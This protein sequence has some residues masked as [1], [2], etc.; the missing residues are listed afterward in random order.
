MIQEAQFTTDEDIGRERRSLAGWVSLDC[1]TC[2]SLLAVAN[3]A[4]RCRTC[5]VEYR[6]SN[7]IWAMLPA[8]R[9][10][11]FA[12][13]L[14][15]YRAVRAAEG[16]RGETPSYYRSLPC[17]SADDPQHAIWRIRERSF[18]ALL[19]H[20]V[21]PAARQGSL[22]VLDLGA[23]N[24][25]LSYQL[26]R[27]GHRCAAVDINDDQHDGLGAHRTYDAP[28]VPIQA[29]FMQLPLAE[30]Q[31][32][33]VLFNA[34]LHYAADGAAA[35]SEALRVL[36]PGG[37]I[38]IIDTPT[39]HDAA[40]GAQMLAER[41]QQ[42]KQ[43]GIHLTSDEEGFLTYARIAQLGRQL[44]LRWRIIHPW[45]GLAWWSRPLR[46]RVRGHRESA[47][48]PL[49]IGVAHDAG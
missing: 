45:R 21:A 28:F 39:Y 31:F 48:F 1:P 27:R 15:S 19:R 4:A 47:D 18:A 42:Y 12:S 46:A 37:S 17:S 10:A 34:A 49:L 24:G 3:D 41:R 25:W 29:D 35:L 36:R 6:Q 8:A 11:E 23:G 7:G 16:W 43:R 38:A 26:A 33:L 44:G 32:D 14:K 30:Q 40:S 5:G 20:A 13:F 2:R 22:N 9:A